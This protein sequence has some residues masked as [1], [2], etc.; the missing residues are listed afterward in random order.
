MTMMYA[1]PVAMNA[2]VIVKTVRMCYD[3]TEQE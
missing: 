2:T 3:L 1:N